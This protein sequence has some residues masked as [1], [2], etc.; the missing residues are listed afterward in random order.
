MGRR[1]QNWTGQGERLEEVVGQMDADYLLLLYEGV[2]TQATLQ[3]Y[4]LQS[5]LA[6]GKS[7]RTKQHT[8]KANRDEDTRAGD[9]ESESESESESVE[10]WISGA[11]FWS[12]ATSFSTSGPVLIDRYSRTTY[13]RTGSTCHAFSALRVGLLRAHAVKRA[14]YNRRK[15]YP[16]PMGR[17]HHV[18]Y[19][20][21]KVVNGGQGCVM[22]LT[23]DSTQ[24][25]GNPG[26]E[27]LTF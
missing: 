19:Q 25:Y 7:S 2:L 10:M 21:L 16:L 23:Q 3:R 22:H 11:R 15:V 12:H 8:E 20:K 18:L 26:L 1:V 5:R 14:G 4:L 6:A 24:R 17:S 13:V 27:F 9:S